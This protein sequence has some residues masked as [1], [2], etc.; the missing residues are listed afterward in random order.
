MLIKHILAIIK[1]TFWKYMFRILIL[2]CFIV[3]CFAES[4]LY[5]LIQN[6]KNNP[7]IQAKI[8]QHQALKQ[9]KNALYSNYLPKIAAGYNYQN[10]TNADLFYPKEAEGF[11][12]EGSFD[13][14]DGFKREGK[15]KIQDSKVESSYFDYLDTQEKVFLEIIT[16]YYSLL[17]AKSKQEALMNQQLELQ[18]NLKKQDILYDAGLI[19]QDSLEAIR[20]QFLQNSYNLEN[21]K[22]EISIY[23]E[24]LSLLSGIEIVDIN[25][26]SK[27]KEVEAN[28]KLP[29]YLLSQR[30]YVRG[31]ES[32]KNLYTYLPTITIFNKYTNY[33][34]GTRNIP[35]LPFSFDIQ[36]PKY[37]N[38]FG[39]SVSFTIFDSFATSFAKES[40]RLNALAA[41][42]EYAYNVDKNNKDRIISKNAL[43]SAKEKIKWAT[44]AL[45]SAQISHSYAREKFN[46]QL[47]DYTEYLSSLTSLFNAQFFFDE[48]YFSYEIQKAK[49]LYVNG[50]NLEEYL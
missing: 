41:N 28:N 42:T 25:K 47:I 26:D 20:S 48:S 30:H 43:H 34:Y 14:F 10:T 2:F 27:L 6:A 50:E 23:K 4:S 33:N 17:I 36:D 19:Q 35:T 39:I 49:F 13:L 22:V 44:S 40:A 8:A 38:V 11:F 18:E 15:I 45:K 37:Q 32:S 21:I 5:E 12:V 16:K 7:L 1:E 24:N 31:V 29:N 9:E 46:A 3:N